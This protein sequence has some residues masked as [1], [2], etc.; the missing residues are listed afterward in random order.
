MMMIIYLIERSFQNVRVNEKDRGPVELSK[1]FTG[2][3]N[4]ENH[5]G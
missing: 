2:P 4:K 1:R 5:H 3:Q